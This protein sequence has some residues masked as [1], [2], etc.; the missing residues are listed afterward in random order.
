MFCKHGAPLGGHCR[1]CDEEIV[2]KANCGCVHHAEEG[3]PCRHDIILFIRRIAG[4]P[5]LFRAC[6]GD[7]AEEMASGVMSDDD[8]IRV[9]LTYIRE[10]NPEPSSIQI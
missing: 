3:I 6:L 8:C 7:L 5:G 9:A 4:E 2:G 1:A 10:M